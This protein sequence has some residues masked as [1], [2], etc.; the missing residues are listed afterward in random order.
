MSNVVIIDYGTGNV[1]SVE[2]ALNRLGAAPVLLC[3]SLAVLRRVSPAVYEAQA[4]TI[5]TAKFKL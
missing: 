3:N 2:Y 4:D 5:E 1:K